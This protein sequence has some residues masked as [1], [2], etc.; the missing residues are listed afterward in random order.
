MRDA[1]CTRLVATF[2]HILSDHG[3]AKCS[4]HVIILFNIIVKCIKSFRGVYMYFEQYIFA[5]QTVVDD[6][7]VLP[8]VFL[9]TD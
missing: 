7:L 5:N 3:T 8:N 9:E 6:Y 1:T 2:T 4:D